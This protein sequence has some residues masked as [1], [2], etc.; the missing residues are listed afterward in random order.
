M[1]HLYYYDP[2]DGRC[3]GTGQSAHVVPNSTELRPTD[4]FTQWFD[5][6]AWI[7]PAPTVPTTE[8][9]ADEVRGL[10]DSLLYESDWTQV[11]DSPVNKTV[12]A[13][14]RQ[15]LRDVT[16]QVG[17]PLDVVWPTTP[18]IGAASTHPRRV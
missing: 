11:A 2:V 14:Y 16:Q 15:E 4:K 1:K 9:V 18:Y 13:A 10:R 6:E 12:W 5:G 3:T 8:E 17:F 7:S